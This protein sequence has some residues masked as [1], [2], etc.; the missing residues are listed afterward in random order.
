MLREKLVAAGKAAL[1]RP[2]IAVEVAGA[3]DASEPQARVSGIPGSGIVD[4]AKAQETVAADGICEADGGR[5]RTRNGP[6][7][8]C[9]M[10]RRAGGTFEC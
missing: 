1:G 10:R 7:I 8:L 6:W 9:T 5:E 3:R 2:A 4:S